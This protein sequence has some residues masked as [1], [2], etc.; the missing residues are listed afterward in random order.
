V[1]V[2]KGNVMIG[3]NPIYEYTA[4]P[5]AKRIADAVRRVMSGVGAR[6][7]MP[8][9]DRANAA[10]VARTM[11][12]PKPAA[13]SEPDAV[14][15]RD[16]DVVVKVPVMGEGIRAARIVS[17]LKQPGDSVALDEALCEVETDK[18]VYPIES[19][20]AGVFKEWRCEVDQVVEIG[21]EIAVIAAGAGAA[22][23]NG[24]EQPATF[25]TPPAAR[26]SLQ[27]LQRRPRFEPAAP[28]DMPAAPALSPAITRRLSSVV[29]ANMQLD[30]PWHAIRAARDAVKA[31][32]PDCSP[33]LMMAWCVVRAM[34]RHD[35]FRRIVSSDGSILQ[36]D[37]LELGIAVALEGD[38]LA[39]AVIGEA[40]QLGWNDFV[41][42]YTRSV[43]EVRSGKISEVQAPLIITS[44]GAFGVEVA[45]PIVVPPSMA[46]LFIGRA[47]ERMINDEGVVH[48]VEVVTLSLTFDHRVV[49]GAGAAAFL[50]EVKAQMIGFRLPE[51]EGE[52][53]TNVK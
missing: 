20:V 10:T 26:E 30:V 21:R 28:K 48:P 43:T 41:T 4:L 14:S 6:P 53:V 13:A 15:S 25:V 49:N 34:E 2:S 37:P 7:L 8:A 33:S 31:R 19:S 52:V 16:S 11:T 45:T 46:T 24:S 29:P 12:A 27:E 1:L 51:H 22:P 9:M 38:Q 32:R 17:L 5:D 42:A 35:A 40:A 23:A 18:A 36:A 50:Q 39:T 47:H 3:Y 44:L